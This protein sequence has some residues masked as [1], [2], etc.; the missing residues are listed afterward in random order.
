V[1]AEPQPTNS[2]VVRHNPAKNKSRAHA[3]VTPGR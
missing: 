2:G 3:L 1:L